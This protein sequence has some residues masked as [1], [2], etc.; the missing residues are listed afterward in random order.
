MN[1]WRDRF[2]KHYEPCPTT[3]CWLWTGSITWSG[4]GLFSAS[5]KRGIPAHR[6]SYELHI[7]KIPNGMYVCHVCDV[8]LCVNPN[9]LFLG[10]H[11]DN[12][13][14]MVSK[15]RSLRGK[16]RL[17]ITH[18]PKGHPYTEKN[19]L[20]RKSHERYGQRICKTCSNEANRARRANR[21]V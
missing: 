8:R 13:R 9:H 3:G 10:T 7:S 2:D 6:V 21:L 12:M 11:Q 15:G 4:Y 14:D 20:F 19:T 5:H 17:D 1:D 18:C 16:L